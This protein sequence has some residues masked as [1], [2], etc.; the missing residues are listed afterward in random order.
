MV[1]VF[2][3]SPQLF[4]GCFTSLRTI[5][6]EA[7][8]YLKTGKIEEARKAIMEKRPPTFKTLETGRD[9]TYTG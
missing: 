2:E 9:Y 3:D 8:K 4:S 1:C 5:K 7:G 6:L